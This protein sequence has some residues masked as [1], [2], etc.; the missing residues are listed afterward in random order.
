MV[1]AGGAGGG[2]CLPPK[3][4]EDA[5][6][7]PQP[8]GGGGA[9]EQG[10]ETGQSKPRLPATLLASLLLLCA[11]LHFYFRYLSSPKHWEAIG[12]GI[13]IFVNA[14][15]THESRGVFPGS[16]FPAAGLA[17]RV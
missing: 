6:V 16:I 9:G 4:R 12:C 17:G 5:S 3:G 11:G 8:S 14:L 7:S 1:A 10:R 13:F 2:T 15:R